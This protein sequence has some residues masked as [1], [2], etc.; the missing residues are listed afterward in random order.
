M[1]GNKNQLLRTEN[2]FKYAQNNQKD[3]RTKLC[4]NGCFFTN[5][6]TCFEQETKS[7]DCLASFRSTII[8]LYVKLDE[9]IYYY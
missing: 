8:I 5:K 6:I 3:P 1:N 2:V 7:A 9:A 4:C